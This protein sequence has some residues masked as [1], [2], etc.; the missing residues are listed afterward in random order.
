MMPIVAVVEVQQ[1]IGYKAV[2]LQIILTTPITTH[3]TVAT[4]RDS[5]RGGGGGRGN[6]EDLSPLFL[7]SYTLG[8]VGLQ[9]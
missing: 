6:R 8:E 3:I 5:S 2:L 1:S 4:I 7:Y 9:V